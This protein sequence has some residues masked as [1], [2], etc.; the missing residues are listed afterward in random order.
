MI[1][2]INRVKKIFALLMIL[3]CLYSVT[4]N[5]SA[6]GFGV[7]HEKAFGTSHWHTG[8]MNTDS[9]DIAYNNSLN[10]AIIHL[11]SLSSGGE[12]TNCTIEY[13]SFNGFN[14]NEA[15]MGYYSALSNP[16]Y[17]ERIQVLNTARQFLQIPLYYHT[18]KQIKYINEQLFY[19]ISQLRVPVA[20][21]TGMRCDGLLEYA[22]ESC[23]IEIYGQTNDS[24]SVWNIS[25]NGFAS[26]NRHSGSLNTIAPEIQAR[27]SMRNQL[28]D[29]NADGVITSEDAR[30]ALRYSVELETPN[31]YQ[32]FTANVTGTTAE[33]SSDDARLI[34]R[35]ATGLEGTTSLVGTSSGY[36]FPNDP[37]N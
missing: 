14:N 6:K 29:I 20:D 34:L 36:R 15:F 33:I 28:G 32:A 7:Y 3:V 8:M 9:P 1:V 2:P 37:F 25:C 35:V 19:S 24:F 13:K 26:R 31:A 18:N 21:I 12:F 22:Y 17:Y 11:E 27:D 23:D 4:A 10:M 30:L 5:A 16:T